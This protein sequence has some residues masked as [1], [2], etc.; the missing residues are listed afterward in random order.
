M[1]FQK[2]PGAN[3]LARRV[4]AVVTEAGKPV[5][6]AYVEAEMG[7]NVHVPSILPTLHNLSRQGYLERIYDTPGAS[8]LFSVPAAKADAIIAAPIAQS[9]IVD[10]L[11]G[12]MA[13]VLA[14]HRP[15]STREAQMI[16][17]GCDALRG[18][19]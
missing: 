19:Q 14:N 13:A 6:A 5:T 10:A 7:D 3:S 16:R 12:L 18:A 11:R 4:L 8:A 2:I 1:A 15:L 9:Q 17:A